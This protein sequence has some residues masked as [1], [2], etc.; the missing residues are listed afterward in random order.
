MEIKENKEIKKNRYIYAWYYTNNNEIFYIGKGTGNRWKDVKSSRNDFFKSIIN[1][2]LSNGEV[3]V[4][5]LYTGLTE[6][7]SL[8]IEK[9]LIKYYKSKGLCKANFH[10][11]GAGGYTGNY[12]SPERSK[13]ISEAMKRAWK[14]PDTKLY[15]PNKGRKYGKWFGEKMSKL[16]TGKKRTEEQRKHYSEAN[17]ALNNDPIR[18]KLKSER[19][20][21]ALKGVKHFEQWTYNNRLSQSK[22]H[23][24]VLYNNK[25]VYDTY[26]TKDLFNFLRNTN[27][28]NILREI[29]S[30]IINGNYK[31]KF[32]KHIELMKHLKIL[33]F[34]KS[35]STIPDECKGVELEISTNSKCATSNKLDEDIVSVVNNI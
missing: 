28:I 8:R 1:K 34:D 10:E 25:L 6:E 4:K 9:R 19:I 29:S 3:S 33:V 22:H 11:G 18:S 13:K 15:S 14:K 20:S 31:P 2:H 32:N 7:E 27:Y 35:V 21:K 26:F 12:D 17:Q 23:Y 30:K 5:K 16:L 24:F